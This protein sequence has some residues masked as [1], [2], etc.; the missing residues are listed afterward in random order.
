MEVQPPNCNSLGTRKMKVE[1]ANDPLVQTT[2]PQVPVNLAVVCCTVY[3]ST[4][5]EYCVKL[6]VP[7]ELQSTVLYNYSN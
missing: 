1:K 5:F 6:S 7:S 3:L 2:G 4:R